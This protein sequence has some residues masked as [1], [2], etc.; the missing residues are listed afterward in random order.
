VLDVNILITEITP[1]IV[2][3]YFTP[4]ETNEGLSWEWAERQNR[5]L[6]KLI[7]D[8]DALNRFVL[9]IAKDDLSELLDSQQVRD[10]PAEEENEVLEN[11]YLGMESEDAQFFQEAQKD[12]IL[13]HNIVLIDRA[14]ETDWKEAKLI[15][16]KVINSDDKDESEAHHAA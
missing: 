15:D 14:F 11:V 4:D 16:L 1:E 7:E 5:L 2:A 10:A 3:S 6:Q 12:G 9:V 13:Y 8:H